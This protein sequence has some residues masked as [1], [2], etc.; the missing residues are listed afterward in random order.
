MKRWLASHTEYDGWRRAVSAVRA[1][2]GLQEACRDMKRSARRVLLLVHPDK[3]AMA[4]PGCVPGASALL[5]ADFNSEYSVQKAK[6]AG[7]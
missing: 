2:H 6:C 1:G 4:H 7:V 3:F 5:A